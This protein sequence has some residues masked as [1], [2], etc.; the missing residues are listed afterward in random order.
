LAKLAFGLGDAE[1]LL[2]GA[3][4]SLPG[5]VRISGLG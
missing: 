4:G 1:W 2:D 5:A 3:W